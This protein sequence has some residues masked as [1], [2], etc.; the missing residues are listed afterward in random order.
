MRKAALVS[1]LFVSILTL[2]KQSS[3]AQYYKDIF[4][5]AG[6]HL[7]DYDEFPVARLLGL[8]WER[9]TAG[10]YPDHLTLRDTVIQKDLYEGSPL[11]ENGI[12][13]Y[14]D[15][16]PRFR[17]IYVHGGLATRHG[18]SMGEVGRNHMR[19]F[20]RGGG[21][22]IG[23]C[24][25]AFLVSMGGTEFDKKKGRCR[26]DQKDFVNDKYLHLFPGRTL[27]THLINS[28]ADLILEKN[29]PLLKY[30]N[31]GGSRRIPLVRHTGGCCI[32]DK[33][34]HFPKG[35]KA[36]LRFDFPGD[37]AASRPYPLTGKI[38]IWSFRDN[39]TSG[40]VIAT[41]SHPESNP[42]GMIAKGPSL[43]LFS[44]LIQYALDNNGPARIKGSLANGE[45]RV[46]DRKT[47]DGDPAHAR[48]GDKQYHH[49]TV[50]I[51]RGA[52]NVTV[53]LEG[54][55]PQDDLHLTLRKGDFAWA[56]EAQYA[57]FDLG[58][59]KTMT[60]PTL[61]AGTWYVG[62]YCDTTVETVPTDWGCLYTGHL[63]VLNGVPYTLSVTWE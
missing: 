19:A 4:V 43:N 54:G 38:A 46:M 27:E 21:S 51:P 48:I 30:S 61:P 52:R 39:D 58:C 28:Y 11:D 42:M 6:I 53:R 10:E 3:Y 36:L 62:V 56:R 17:M 37:T 50:K 24:A 33:A 13:L 9:F 31:F 14:P 12:W 22:Y 32:V 45:A 60:F 49:F 5:D 40:L 59:D 16:A 57:D 47:S 41:G 1:L 18:N 35:T 20:V 8:S 15:G 44:A 25:G 26:D 55:Y 2:C 7:S 63:E 34:P 29:S 23:S